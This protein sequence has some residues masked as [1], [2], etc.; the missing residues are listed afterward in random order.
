MEDAPE[1]S[2]AT[3]DD[4]ADTAASDAASGADSEERT[5][6]EESA[7]NRR[8]MATEADRRAETDDREDYA[9][10]EDQVA[11]YEWIG[12]ISAGMG[13][14]MTPLLAGPFAVYCAFQIRKEKPVTAMMLLGVVLGTV[15]FWILALFLIIP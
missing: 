3:A 15:V 12:G 1:A 7:G 10:T 2:D 13:I 8:L 11:F 4:D 9:K 6:D 14:F 5:D